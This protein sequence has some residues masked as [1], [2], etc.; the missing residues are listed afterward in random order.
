MHAM[1]SDC[2]QSGRDAPTDV[3]DVRAVHCRRNGDTIP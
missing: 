2:K 3:V 1:H